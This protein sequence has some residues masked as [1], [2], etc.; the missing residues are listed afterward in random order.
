MAVDSSDYASKKKRLCVV[1]LKLF[2]STRYNFIPM[3]LKV[4]QAQA[5]KTIKAA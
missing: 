2:L 4:Q 3:G 1:S 5:P